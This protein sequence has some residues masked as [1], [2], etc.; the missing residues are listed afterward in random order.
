MRIRA[1]IEG[2]LDVYL[3]REL[4]A[5]EKAVT[6]AMRLA[7]DRAKRE[8]RGQVTGAG[9]GGRMA[10]A[11]RSQVYPRAGASLGAGALVWTRAPDVMRAFEDGATIRGRAGGW[12]AIPTGS[13][14]RRGTDGKR[15]RP[16]T[17]PEGRFGPL[18]FVARNGRT[19]L[20]VV[21]NVRISAK[22]GRVGRRAANARTKSGRLRSGLTSV[23]MFVLVRQVRLQK[24]LDFAGAGARADARLPGLIVDEWT[25]EEAKGGR[26]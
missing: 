8:I 18:R 20:L 13:A 22:T 19:A 11:V 25:A 6:R 26:R 1:A 16:D 23:V 17:F 14:P 4:E 21:D 24:R 12:L 15:I 3:K 2:N 9:L 7:S 5:G 10:N